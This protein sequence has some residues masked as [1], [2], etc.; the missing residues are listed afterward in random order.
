MC[1]FI[2]RGRRNRPTLLEKEKMNRGLE[3]S[4]IKTDKTCTRSSDLLLLAVP[5]AIARRIP[6]FFPLCSVSLCA[7][8]SFWGRRPGNFGGGST[9]CDASFIKV[10]YYAFRIAAL[11]EHS[12]GQFKRSPCTWHWLVVCLNITPAN[13]AGLHVSNDQIACPRPL[14]SHPVSR[15]GWPVATSFYIIAVDRM[16]RSIHA[17]QRWSPRVWRSSLPHKQIEDARAERPTFLRRS[18]SRSHFLCS[19]TQ[20]GIAPLFTAEA[21]QKWSCL[22]SAFSGPKGMSRC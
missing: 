1:I 17:V 11:G 10:N 3:M 20:Y 9:S 12:S 18:R 7:N 22:C 2:D 14:A 6:P 16:M 15:A 21:A 8:L 5:P 19:R 13:R 4:L